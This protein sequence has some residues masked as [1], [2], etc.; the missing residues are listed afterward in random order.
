[1]NTFP[2]FQKTKMWGT[3][4]NETGAN[5]RFDARMHGNIETN[6]IKV[7][8]TLEEVFFKCFLFEMVDMVSRQ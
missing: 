1:M 4:K 2:D 6:F 8:G 3:Q 7:K 5:S